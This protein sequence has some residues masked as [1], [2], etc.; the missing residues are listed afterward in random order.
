MLFFLNENILV[1]CKTRN[2]V[3]GCQFIERHCRQSSCYRQPYGTLFIVSSANFIYRTWHEFHDMEHLIVLFLY[4][5]NIRIYEYIRYESHS[6][7]LTRMKLGELLI[8]QS[9]DTIRTNLKQSFNKFKRLC[10]S[11]MLDTQSCMTHL[12]FSS[13]LM[14]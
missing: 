11:G 13:E 5:V 2:T 9:D 4:Y 8:F 14:H 10:M 3:Y 7:V 12:C 1:L 6:F